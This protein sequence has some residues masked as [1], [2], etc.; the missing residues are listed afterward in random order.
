MSDWHEFIITIGPN[1]DLWGP[2]LF[3]LSIC[4]SETVNDGKIPFGDSIASV[5]VKAYTGRVVLGTHLDLHTEITDLIDPDYT[6][7][8]YNG[9][10]IKMKFQHP[11]GTYTGKVTLVFNVT[12]TS[13]GTKTFYFQ[14][15]KIY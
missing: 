9:D 2:Y 14:Y 7:I 11:S 10:T 13:G 8:I 6:I 3:R 15:I 4:S 5:V 1:T 12:L